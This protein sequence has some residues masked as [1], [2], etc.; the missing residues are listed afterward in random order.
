MN[1]IN[2]VIFPQHSYILWRGKVSM[3]N[4]TD[5]DLWER[6]FGAVQK[7][8]VDNKIQNVGAGTAIYFSWDMEHHTT[9]MGIGNS[10][11]GVEQINDPELVLVKVD[12]S[13]AAH[14]LV[15]GSYDKLRGAHGELMDYLKEYK[16]NPSIVIEEYS[17]MGS[18]GPSDLETNLYH[19]YK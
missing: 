13:K 12:E 17:N 15:K 11:V 9:D 4:I 7:Y 1:E 5:R 19:L 14:M 18:S 16:F 10:V 3:K 2:E 8:I 6:A